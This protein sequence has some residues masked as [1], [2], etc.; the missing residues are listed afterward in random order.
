[1]FF[2][3]LTLFGILKAVVKVENLKNTR[4]SACHWFSLPHKTLQPQKTVHPSKQKHHPGDR[5]VQCVD[6]K[7][8]RIAA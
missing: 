6:N 4:Y 3:R 5:L 1:M 2:R 7:G 8:C